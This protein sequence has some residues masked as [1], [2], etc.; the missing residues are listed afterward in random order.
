MLKTK[1][2]EFGFSTKK[3]IGPLARRLTTHEIWC[4]DFEFKFLELT[5]LMTD[6]QGMENY[7]INFDTFRTKLR[8]GY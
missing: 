7:V 3:K 5:E 1:I 2:M 4:V 8:I 6:D